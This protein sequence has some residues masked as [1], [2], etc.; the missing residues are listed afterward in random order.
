MIFRSIKSSMGRF[1][2]IFAISALGVG[3]LAGLSAAT[4][5]MALSGSRYFENNR[6]ADV[7]VLSNVGLDMGDAEELERIDGVKSVMAVKN[8]DALFVTPENE[9]IGVTVIGLEPEVMLDRPVNR[10]TLVSGR[11]PEKSGECLVEHTIEA[12]AALEIGEKLEYSPQN[13]GDTDDIFLP[14]Q[15]TVVGVVENPY[16]MSMQREQTSVGNGKISQV[17]YVSEDAFD[18]DYYTAVYLTVEGAEGEISMSDGY[19]EVASPV[20]DRIEKLA[21]TQKYSRHGRVLSEAREKIDDAWATYYDKKA[22]ADGEFAKAED[23]IAKAEADIADGKRTLNEK[24]TEARQEIADGEREL[25][26]AYE[27]LV[28]GEKDLEKGKQDYKDGKKEYE[29]GLAK[30]Q[31]GLKEYEPGRADYEEGLAEYEKGKKEYEDGEKSLSSGRRRLREAESKYDAGYAQY[32]AGLEQLQAGQEQLD[33]SA[34][35]L[36]QMLG[37]SGVTSAQMLIDI[38]DSD[39]VVEAAIG[40]Y[41]VP[42]RQGQAEL[43]E[44]RAVLEATGRQ[45]DE[46]AAQISRGWDKIYDGENELK[47]AKRQLL[48]AWLT[49]E[50]GRRE[51]EEAEAELEDARAELEDAK[52]E[53]EDAEKDIAR[54]ETDL[55]DGWREYYDGVKELEDGKKELEEEVS[56]ARADIAKGEADLAEGKKDYEEAKAEAEQKLADAEYE[57]RDAEAKLEDISEPK[58]YVLDRDSILVTAGFDSNIQKVASIAKVFPVFFFMIAA[59]VCLTTMTRMVEEERGLIGTMKALG[60]SSGAISSKYLIYAF[61]ASVTGSLLGLTVGFRVF[62]EVIW[63]AY[64]IMYRLPELYTPFNVGYA[65]FSSL[66]TLACIMA[67]TWWVCRESLGESAASLMLP[68]A[69]QPGKRV[70]LEKIDFIWSRLSFNGKVTV[71]N[72]FRYKKRFFMTVVGVSGCAALLV[73]G[74]GLRDSISDILSNQ[75]ETLWGFDLMVGVRPPDEEPIDE[76][77]SAIVESLDGYMAV[78][79]ESGKVSLKGGVTSEVTI[80][81]P[82][83]PNMFAE[84]YV[85]F[86]TRVGHNSVEFGPGRA[87]LTEKASRTIGA[88]VGDE[89]TLEDADGEQV[90][91]TLAGIT[92]NYIQGFIYVA[93]DLYESIFGRQAEMNM[94]FCRAGRPDEETRE[95]LARD[96]LKCSSAVSCTFTQ[97]TAENFGDTFKSID[98]IVIVLIVSAGLLAFVVLYNLTNININERHKEIATLKVLGFY[99][100]EV[101]SYI[102]KETNILSALGGLMGMALGKVLHAFVVRTAEVDMVMFGRVIVTKSYFNA[103]LMTM[104]FS[105]AVSLF[106]LKRLKKVSM[107]ESLKAPE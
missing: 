60:Y 43:D 80:Y 85:L 21:E 45:L 87:V 51:L 103:F 56:K 76:R 34:A 96:I 48:N 12:V 3:F 62:P 52:I 28:Q 36:A 33:A 79:Q 91:V 83:D 50:D 75:F 26:D 73:A 10:L 27:E 92:E 1:A 72:L 39:P 82:E 54:A 44:S 90:T 71:R 6:L 8:L 102:L 70:F 63:H 58:W 15:L 95:A 78:G 20:V 46:A 38:A 86:R 47:K 77:L 94:L 13:D 40:A 84:D 22:E 29:D 25:A 7:R 64:G 67:A 41:L 11:L 5:D 2:A 106:M 105:L 81:V 66:S 101:A 68:K 99:E 4:P 98:M 53:L 61:S 32:K 24:E 37:L 69:P 9:T 19:W 31:D 42:I 35:A 16:Y 93:P 55:K 74:F 100:G 104:L 59:L 65:A 97:D 14:R 30:Y 89:I 18:M 49:L 17:V 23:K 107:V 88:S 57:I